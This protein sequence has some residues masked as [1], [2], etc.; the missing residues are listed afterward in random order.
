MLIVEEDG[1]DL[2]VK[3][4]VSERMGRR[5]SAAKAHIVQMTVQGEEASLSFVV[6]DAN[7]CAER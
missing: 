4:S 2:L 1:S 7:F 5:Q 6:E 3:M